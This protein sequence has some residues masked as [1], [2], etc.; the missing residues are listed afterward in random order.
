MKK[1]IVKKQVFG[2][3]SCSVRYLVIY[4]ANVPGYQES[5][6]NTLGYKFE[7]KARSGFAAWLPCQIKMCSV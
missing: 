2:V 4:L 7:E 6:I 5:A 3:F 1:I